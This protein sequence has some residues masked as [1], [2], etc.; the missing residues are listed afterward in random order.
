MACEGRPA[1]LDIPLSDAMVCQKQGGATFALQKE[2]KEERS[3]LKLVT[4]CTRCP[5]CGFCKNTFD[6]FCPL[7]F[8][9]N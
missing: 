5:R 3:G 2:P 6:G 9:V 7:R 4:I 8:H 1:L